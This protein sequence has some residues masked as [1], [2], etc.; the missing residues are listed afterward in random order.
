MSRFSSARV[1]E[2][3]SCNSSRACQCLFKDVQHGL[4]KRQSVSAPIQG[5]HGLASGLGAVWKGAKGRKVY[6]FEGPLLFRG[7]VQAGSLRL[8]AS[9]S[10][11]GRIQ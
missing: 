10:G 3:P 7:T 4:L 9:Y 5:R 1:C 6:C 11:D 2:Q 8:K